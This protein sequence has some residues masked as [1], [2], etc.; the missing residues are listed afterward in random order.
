MNKSTTIIC[1]T[2]KEFDD[3][4]NNQS[5]PENLV[6]YDVETNARPVHSKDHKVIGFSL[7]YSSGI[8]CYVPL[9]A[10]D[11]QVSAQDTIDIK[12]RLSSILNTQDIMVYN[13][14][15]EYPV[16]LNWLNL[17]IPKVED[18]FVMV[19]LMMG[20][21]DKYAGNGG[22]K[23]QS[24]MYLGYDNWS[25]DVQLYFDYIK[26]IDKYWFEL[27]S[28]LKGYY[29]E[30]EIDHLLSLIKQI[31]EDELKRDV[32]SYEY[33]PYKL[34]GK[35]G[36]LDVT[37]LFDLKDYY[38]D[39]IKKENEA[40]GI[41]LIQGYRYW[42]DHHYA[43]YVLERNGAYWNEDKVKEIEE[44]CINGKKKSWRFLFKSPLT[45]EWIK[46]SIYDD[47]LC[48]LMLEHTYLLSPKYTPI[49][50][51][52]KKVEVIC[53]SIEAEKELQRMSLE[54]ISKKNKNESSIIYSLEPGNFYHLIQPKIQDGSFDNE[55]C[56]KEFYAKKIQEIIL[57][58][59]EKKAS[60]IFNP[61]SNNKEF[62]SF[63]SGILVTD[64]I[65]LA[66]VYHTILSLADSNMFDIDMYKD[67]FNSKTNK[68]DNFYKFSER[69]VNEYSFSQ[70]KARNP[71]YTY[72]DNE[73]SKLIEKVFKLNTSETKAKYR[74]FCKYLE[75]VQYNLTDPNLK[76]LINDCINYKLDAIDEGNMIELY[77]LYKFVGCDIEDS[78]TWTPGFRWLVNLRWYKKY[79]KML[80]TYINGEN[81]RKS[82]WYLPKDSFENGDIFTPRMFPYFSEEGE[83]I[84]KDPKLLEKYDTV[85]QTNFKVNVAD[86]GR[87]TATMHTLPAGTTVKGFITS[88]Y[89]GGMI[90]MPDCSQAEVR[91]LAAISQDE[92]LLNAFRQEGMDIHKYVASLCNQ[93]PIEEV[94]SV[95]RKIA[96]SAVFGILYGEPLK[97][98]AQKNCHGDIE[99]ARKIY[100]FFYNAFPKIKEYVEECHRQYLETKKVILPL[101]H[102]YIDMSKL[103]DTSDK[104]K[105]LRQSQNFPCQGCL[106]G[107]TMIKTLD[108]ES[109]PIKN[110]VGLDKFYLYSFDPSKG[111][112]VPS[113]GYNAH[114]TKEV[115][116][117]YKVTLDNGVSILCTNNH[118]FLLR[119]GNYVNAEN[120]TVG[121]SL[122]PMYWHFS[123]KDEVRGIGNGYEIIDQIT[124]K[125]EPTYRLVTEE[126]NIPIAD[127]K[128]RHHK[129]L[130]KNN[131]VPE[132]IEELSI[133]E[134]FKVHHKAVQEL[135]NKIKTGENLSKIEKEIWNTRIAS[136]DKG[137]LT[138]ISSGMLS[139]TM[140]YKNKHRKELYPKWY[141]NSCDAHKKRLE[142]EDNIFKTASLETR[143]SWSRKRYDNESEKQKTSRL[144]ALKQGHNSDT[145]IQNHAKASVSREADPIYNFNRIKKQLG[146][147]YQLGI[148]WTDLKNWDNK[149][150]KEQVI[151][152]G[153]NPMNYRSSKQIDKIGYD[154]FIELGT[155]Y[156]RTYN[157]KVTNIEVITY[158]TPI[159]VYDL[160]VPGYDNFVIDLGD[161]SGVVVHNSC[162]DVAGLILYE[163]CIYIAKE[164]MKSKPFCFIHDSIE[165]DIHPDELF[166]MLD[167]LRP[168]FNEYPDKEFGVPMA[169][170]I[171]FSCHMGAEID[172]VKLESDTEYNDVWITLKGFKCDIDEVLEHWKEVYDLVEKDPTFEEEV[173]EEY[174]PL[175][176]LFTPKVTISK[177]FGTT[178]QKIKTRYHI[179]RKQR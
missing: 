76:K 92:N 62:Y 82:V 23:M 132:N 129:D 168:I 77:Q 154:L 24:V 91:I 103:K 104:D 133:S 131:N 146:Y 90:A 100:E 126:F 152:L 72:L 36:A 35:Y 134:H 171:V 26:N 117:L 48:Y 125:K 88:R 42:M 63:V 159:P 57:E 6:G 13:C 123:K 20:N 39:W 61:N 176:G 108:G 5:N 155:E 143:H 164:K 163:I 106:L 174:V 169:S 140:A 3:F 162:V 17:E 34:V 110:L 177:E 148:D 30:T 2:Y 27:I 79:N 175:E 25:D 149:T 73:D 98:F 16:T 114:I 81:G 19:K 94:T 58:D 172:V 15:H 166:K 45:Q 49:K 136:L 161:N 18:L 67:Y 7:A 101:T 64:E 86:S 95:Q 56:F 10:L 33:I 113:I 53:T 127:G 60:K 68:I 74:I 111:K 50:V 78:S 173:K 147:M 83:R 12:N 170:D 37:V 120:L 69:P 21:V 40:L 178:K 151:A 22:L 115:S 138:E 139:K 93:I 135:S 153:L 87:W 167:Q 55:A 1:K 43:G 142:S 141:K 52:K 38:L 96:K 84:R 59:N 32:I 137:R 4:L 116:Q 47:Y 109:K 160:T 157:H 145:A 11:F 75:K 124:G 121:T 128:I 29:D 54:P 105:P 165:I 8:G 122:M 70:I 46:K 112:I 31:P 144:A 41:D 14:M 51:Y 97:S 66:K 119:T 80:S 44:W 130:N 179:I 85:L 28:L 150:V 118:P 158:D 102:R 99:Q 71:H 65:K 9:K 156:L 89:K 107:N